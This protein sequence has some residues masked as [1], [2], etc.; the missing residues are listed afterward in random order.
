MLV[1]KMFS[2]RWGG[3]SSGDLAGRGRVWGHWCLL[4]LQELETNHLADGSS[5]KIAFQ[6]SLG[7]YGAEAPSSIGGSLVG[8]LRGWLGL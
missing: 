8:E 3:R 6:A 1:R 7:Y 4:E 2:S 5:L